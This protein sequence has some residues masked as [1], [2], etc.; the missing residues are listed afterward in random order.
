MADI[1]PKL[2][3]IGIVLFIVIILFA[4]CWDTVEP[5]EW[6][7]NYNTLSKTIDPKTSKIK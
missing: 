6:G 1:P 5:T 2:I 7:L 4:L 3:C